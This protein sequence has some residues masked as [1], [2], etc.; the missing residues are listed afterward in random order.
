MSTTAVIGLGI[1]A[2]VLV[3][4][5]LALFAGRMIRLRD[6]QRPDR[7]EPVAPVEPGSGD[8]AGSLPARPRWRLRNKT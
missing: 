5:L 1:F 8:G 6:R 4:I 3:A 2:W 7:T